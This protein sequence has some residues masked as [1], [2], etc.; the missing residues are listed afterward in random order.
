MRFWILCFSVLFRLMALHAQQLAVARDTLC[1]MENGKVLKMPW[2]NGINYSNLSNLDLNFD[3]IK[4]LVVY[5]RVNHLN[6]GRFRCFI[7]TGNPGST[8]Y[9]YSPELSYY[10]PTVYNWALCLDYNCDG[11]EDLFC[12][13]NS[14]IKVYR[15]ESS[16]SNPINFVLAKS[17]INSNYNPGGPPLIG[18]IYASSVGAPGF[19]DV[20]N[21]GDIDILSF[22][23]QGFLIEYHKNR[24]KETYGH[25]DSLNYEFQD[26]CWGK[27]AESS[28]SI[29]LNQCLPKPLQNKE[30]TI[31]GNKVYH[32]GSCLTCFDSDG[33]GDKDLVMGDIA[34]N[35]VQYAHNTGNLSSAFMGD[36]T[37]LYPNYPNK[38]NTLRIQINN[39]PCAYYVDAD[40]DQKKDLVATPSAFGSENTASVWF[41]RNTSVTNTVNFQFVKKNLLQDEMIEVGQ[42][43]FPVV[44]DENGDGK[45]DLLIGT[46]G[47]Y[48]TNTLQSKLT[49]YRNTGSNAQPTYSLITRDYAGLS[50]QNLN[51][52][53]PSIGDI[54]ND[55]DK[56]LLIGTSSGQ[57]HWLENTA[58]AGNACNFSIFKNNP[59]SFTT[60]S[61]EA[62]PQLFDMDLDGKKDLMIGMK[63]GRVAYYRNTGSSSVPAFSLITSTF[64]NIDVRDNSGTFW[65]DGYAVP[66]FYREG[67]QTKLISGS[68]TGNLFLYTV[69]LNISQNCTLVNPSLNNYNEGAQSAPFLEDVNADGKPDLFL[70]NAGGG[71]SF[72]SS[73][74]PYVS[75]QEN[76]SIHLSDC[77]QLFPV[78]TKDKLRVILK[79]LDVDAASLQLLD[80]SGRILA[81]YPLTGYETEIDLKGL[82]SGLYLGVIQIQKEGKTRQLSRKILISE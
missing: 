58:G 18:N 66:F 52:V 34:C 57:I 69:P 68:I 64:G 73:A 72:F 62:A 74:S 12:S 41:Y 3:G 28:C 71:L 6:M 33:D 31:N 40:G 27:F 51:H 24:S 32:A 45:K 25:C 47:Y 82:N 36:T 22:S 39:F 23:S 60:P 7:K 46:Y 81:Y 49:L 53:M 61:A 76:E 4:D 29:L 80:L 20:D 79:N 11:K 54:D 43:A 63:N 14:G 1:V 9:S 8:T 10:F 5:D 65:I 55:G 77:V 16:P 13:T 35:N 38:N 78:P 26:D 2:A 30:L 56:D 59:F 15:N 67:G 75:I 50:A 42:N 44:F 17:I 21:D 70:G 48:Q 37:A 19:A